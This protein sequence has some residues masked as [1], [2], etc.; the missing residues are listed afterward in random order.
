MPTQDPKL[1][2]DSQRMLKVFGSHLGQ[3]SRQLAYC[4]ASGQRFDATFFDRE[5][6]LEV[7]L[8]DI[9]ASKFLAAVRR[10]L[11]R[12]GPPDVKDLAA[13]CK[14]VEFSD[15]NVAPLA[16]IWILNPMPPG[17]IDNEALSRADLTKAEV[18]AGQNGETIREMIRDTY[19][20]ESAAEEDYFVRRWIAS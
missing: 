11:V 2:A 10:A 16:S 18:R 4:A 6:I 17:G 14:R 13:L 1:A 3:I 7:S 19:R 15:G 20:C 9:F 5:P 8:D 12:P